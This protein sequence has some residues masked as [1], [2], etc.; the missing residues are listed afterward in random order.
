MDS[1]GRSLVSD[2][3]QLTFM[4][5]VLISSSGDSIYAELTGAEV[6]KGE[7]SICALRFVLFVSIDRRATKGI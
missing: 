7:T 2:G 4:L 6:M 1:D 5:I 3:D